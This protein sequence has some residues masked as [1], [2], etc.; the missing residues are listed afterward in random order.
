MKIMS[1]V[2]LRILSLSL[3]TGPSW[4]LVVY[5]IATSQGHLDQR[6]HPLPAWP[7]DVV[8]PKALLWRSHRRRSSSCRRVLKHK[9]GVNVEGTRTFQTLTLFLLLTLPIEF[10]VFDELQKGIALFEI[11]CQIG[12]KYGIF[13]GTHNRTVILGWESLEVNKDDDYWWTIFV[14]HICLKQPRKRLKMINIEI[15]AASS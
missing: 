10:S 15:T 9:L 2:K 7:N 3:L 4:R 13:H 14:F 12:W 8:P 11:H 6:T 5:L 1:S